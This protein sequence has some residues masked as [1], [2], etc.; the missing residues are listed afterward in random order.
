MRVHHTITKAITKTGASINEFNGKFV[1]THDDL[2]L[3]AESDDARDLR[4]LAQR[5]ANGE[6]MEDYQVEDQTVETDDEEEDLRAGSVVKSHYKR[7]YKAEGHPDN[8]G[9]WLAYVLREMTRNGDD[10]FLE[11][12]FIAIVEMNGITD[13]FKYITDKNGSTGRMVMNCS[14]RLRTIVR[15]AGVLHTPRGDL[16]PPAE[17]M[18][19]D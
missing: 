4:A 5:W 8:C 2:G 1:L 19:R 12:E 13:W 14:N 7:L 6:D 15:K 9:D 3:R 10:V 16:T 18:N 17:F 11:D